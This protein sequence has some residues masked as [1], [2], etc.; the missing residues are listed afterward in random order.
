MDF[1]VGLPRTLRKFDVV[2]VIVDSLTKSAYFIPSVTTFLERLARIYIQKIVR[3]HGVPVSINSDRGPQ[4][5]SHFWRAV[6]SKLG[7]WV[8]LSTTFHSQTDGQSE[9]TI[10]I[11]EDILRACVIDFAVKDALE[12]VK[13]IQERLRT[14]QSRQKSYTDHKA[15]DLSIM[16]G[17]KVLL[18]VSSMKWIVRFGKKGKL[19]PR[20]HML[21]YNIVQLDESLGYEEEPVAIIDMQVHQLRSKKIATVKVHWRVQ[22]VE[23]ETWEAKEDM[24]SRYPHLFSTPGYKS[25]GELILDSGNM[26]ELNLGELLTQLFYAMQVWKDI[27]ILGG[28]FSLNLVY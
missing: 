18:K 6:Q 17:K 24:R 22:P 25:I 28:P 10:Q 16:V 23:K 13:L 19:S 7:T 4:F 11:L 21:Y 9:R 1:V 3:L 27:D 8:E 14:A 20:S 15:R 2:W 5:T 12:K 26:F